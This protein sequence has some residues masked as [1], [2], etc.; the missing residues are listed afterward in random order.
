LEFYIDPSRA[1]S[2]AGIMKLAILPFD[3]EGNP[4]AVRHE[5]ANPGKISDVAPEIKVA[6]KRTDYGYDLEFKVPVKYLNLEPAPGMN[7]GF[8]YTIHNSNMKDA[9]L[10]EY[11]RE[12]IISWNNLPDIW[13]HPENWGTLT[14]K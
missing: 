6:T 14:L 13:A 8:C 3:T 11:V 9:G 10:G 7:L 5:D 12:N 2:D 4:Q 1:G